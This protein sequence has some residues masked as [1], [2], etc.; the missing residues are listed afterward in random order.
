MRPPSSPG[1][2]LHKSST[3][4]HRASAPGCFSS[5]GS[6][7]G[8]SGSSL[9][10][11]PRA[12]QEGNARHVFEGPLSQSSPNPLISFFPKL[13]TSDPSHSYNRQPSPHGETIEAACKAHP[14]P[15]QC[16]GSSKGGSIGSP[17]VLP[18][19]LLDVYPNEPKAATWGESCTR[20]H[21]SAIHNSQ[22]EVT[23][24]LSTEERKPVWSIH[25][26]QCG[27]AS[28]RKGI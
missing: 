13:L 28:K 22:G 25:T 3:P 14:V 19:P 6:P 11:H 16:G 26:V 20:V 18:I 10:L 12:P 15:K 5:M 8:Y 2:L 24:D 4:G 17:R 21:S 9:S 23:R 1:A 7:D 27:S